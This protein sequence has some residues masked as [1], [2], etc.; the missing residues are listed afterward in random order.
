[1][2][3]NINVLRTGF[4]HSKGAYSK[5]EGDLRKENHFIGR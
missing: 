2:G 1:L 4:V 5:I 3:R